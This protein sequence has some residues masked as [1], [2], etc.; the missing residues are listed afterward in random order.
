MDNPWFFRVM[1][2]WMILAVLR[3]RAYPKGI[4]KWW[5]MR[6]SSDEG[7]GWIRGN[8]TLVVSPLHPDIA[9]LAP[10]G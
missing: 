7:V 2:N 5:E 6:L 10:F 9:I 3:I 4:D 1:L 8:G